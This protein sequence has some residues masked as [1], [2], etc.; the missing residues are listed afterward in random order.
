MPGVGWTWVHSPGGNSLHQVIYSSFVLCV[1]A[2]TRCQPPC[3]AGANQGVI[4]GAG[5]KVCLDCAPPH[6]LHQ[7]TF[8]KGAELVFYH[9]AA[10][11]V[12]CKIAWSLKAT[13]LPTRPPPLLPHNLYFARP[14]LS[15]QTDLSC[16]LVFQSPLL[17]N[18]MWGINSYWII[19]SVMDSAMQ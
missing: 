9:W 19:F 16:F 10:T 2:P 4:S 14:L 15:L 5:G 3:A 7:L 18:G 13:M 6:P 11:R 12:L 8:S 17:C 1:L